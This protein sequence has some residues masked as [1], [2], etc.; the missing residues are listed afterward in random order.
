MRDTRVGVS[1]VQIIFH[2]DDEAPFE[3][4]VDVL[5]SVSGRSPIKANARAATVGRLARGELN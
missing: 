3:L 2:D 1:D 5:Q 4:V